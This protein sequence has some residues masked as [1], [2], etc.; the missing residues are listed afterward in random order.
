[1]LK[2]IKAI[3]V[4]RFHPA[5][6][7]PMILV[8]TLA[9]A[10]YFHFKF[11]DTIET[12]AITLTFIIMLSAFFRLR[13]FD[14]IKD[15]QTDLKIN[16]GRPLAR[17]A[18]SITETKKIIFILILL[19]ASLAGFLGL[20]PFLFHILALAYSLLMY[21]EF[22]VGENLRPHLT[23]YAVTHTF[24]SV[25]LGISA[26]ALS[27]GSE[28]FL[29]EKEDLLFFLMNWTYFNL[30]EFARKTYAASEERADVPTYSLL[31][32]PVGAAALSL[33]QVILGIYFLHEVLPAHDFSLVL[34]LASIYSLF[35][36]LFAFKPTVT[37]AKIFRS[38]T[39][40]YLLIHYALL[41]WIF[42]S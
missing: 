9:N 34:V 10:L 5:Q 28:S 17:Q 13:L 32:K 14:E 23:T 4:E 29:I 7:L 21:E 33:S 41:V 16:P 2:G 19:E 38:V 18:I 6:Y 37:I 24:V 25:L 42:W 8:F 35:C 31:F 3:I 40:A 39:G 15:Y 11:Q 1:M 12:K 22:F 30:F 26:A 36:L 27:N 20:I